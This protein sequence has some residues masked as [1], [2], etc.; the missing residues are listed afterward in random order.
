MKPEQMNVLL[1][2]AC[3]GIGQILARYLI[4][5]GAS[6]YL[7]GRKKE[8]LQALEQELR[9]LARPEQEIKSFCVDLTNRNELLSMVENIKDQAF[10]LNV[11]INN[12][13]ISRLELFENASETDI[14]KMIQLNSLVP[15]MLTHKL[16]PIIRRQKEGRIVNVAST[17]GGVGFPG[18][19]VYS[20]SKFAIRGFSEALGRELS[21]S[22]VTVG[23]FSPRAS[24]TPINSDKAVELNRRM[25]V[26]MDSPEKVANELLTF[27]CGNRRNCAVGW[28]ERLLLP[29][30]ALFPDLIGYLLERKLPLIKR[31]AA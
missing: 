5:E 2:G 13:G 15:V 16:L 26:T 18:Y 31:Y 8:P 29:V 12:A 21:D 17:L 25:N 1:T 9:P 3:G 4:R 23:C 28:P 22:S 19:S 24:M 30:N 11:L 7:T 10:E 14:D 27:V 6:L 20:S